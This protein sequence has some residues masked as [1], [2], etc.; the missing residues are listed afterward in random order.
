MSSKT[1]CDICGD[2]M[3]GK[4]TPSGGVDVCD[5][6][7][8]NAKTGK[9]YVSFEITVGLNGKWNVG[10][11]CKYCIINAVKRFDDRPQCEPGT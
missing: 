10:D 4:N 9:N 1:F 7:G 6:L 11:I 5:R 3:D 2:E 8:G